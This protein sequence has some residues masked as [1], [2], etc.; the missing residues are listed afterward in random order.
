MTESDILLSLAAIVLILLATRACA[1]L[2]LGLCGPFRKDAAKKDPGNCGLFRTPTLRN[3]AA[4]HAFF[5]NGRF[6]S[7]REALL[8]YVE[9]DIDPGKWY[10]TGPNGKVEKFDDLP[11]QYR[12]NVDTDDAPLDR[13][14]GEKPAWDERQIEDLTAFLKTLDDQ[15]VVRQRSGSAPRIGASY[16]VQAN[17]LSLGYR[18]LTSIAVE[19][20][21]EADCHTIHRHYCGDSSGPTT[22][23][24]RL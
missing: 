8:F 13:K 9:R 17:D 19:A 6:H 10:P 15:D 21:R 4:R 23:T 22:V 12:K 5:H 20:V 16:V 11:P 3:T 18:T 14:P 7:L 1:E 24:I 2:D